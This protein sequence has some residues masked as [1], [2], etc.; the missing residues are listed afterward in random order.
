MLK[1][2]DELQ[3]GLMRTL[4]DLILSLYNSIFEKFTKMKKQLDKK[5]L[6]PEDIAE[7]D[8]IKNNL[9]FDTSAIGKEFDDSYKIIH[10]LLGADHIFTDNLIYKTDEVIKCQKK[11]REFQDEYIN[12]KEV[13][14]K[15][16]TKTGKTLKISINL[17][18]RILKVKLL[19]FQKK[20]LSWK[21]LT[22]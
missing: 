18:N 5:L 2:L 8:K 17:K 9:V 22:I 6:T 21:E 1:R 13:L 11:F 16:I 14:K 20:S 10:Y 3:N 15:L 19:N 4:E 12:I 7:M